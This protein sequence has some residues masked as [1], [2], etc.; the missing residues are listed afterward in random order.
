MPRFP[1]ERSLWLI[2][3]LLLVLPLLSSCAPDANAQIL[4]PELEERMIAEASGNAADFA[5]TPT[6]LL[7]Q[8]SPEQEFAGLEEAAPGVAQIISSGA[9]DPANG[10]TL[11][12]TQGCVGCHLLD[13]D[14]QVTAPTWYNLGNKAVGRVPGESPGLY[15]Y[16]S[17]AAPNEYIVS[18]YQEGVMVS[19]YRESL[20]D[21]DFADLITYILSQQQETPED[22]DPNAA[23]AEGGTL[24]D[25]V[26]STATNALTDTGTITGTSTVTDPVT[27]SSG[28]G[29][30]EGAATDGE[31]QPPN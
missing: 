19:T 24:T 8:L 16:H 17:I 25:T 20:T 23:S 12:A 31:E 9:A 10:E 1:R 15:L 27:E 4:S 11:A 2:G 21:Q 5:P 3:F 26:T 6:P 28:E 30:V 14:N 29:D 18:G 13:P 7:A 22:F